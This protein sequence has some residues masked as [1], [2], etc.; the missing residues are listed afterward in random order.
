MPPTLIL[1]NGGL[2]SVLQTTQ[3][4][5]ADHNQEQPRISL[6]MMPRIYPSMTV[7]SCRN[8]GPETALKTLF[9]PL[10]I[11]RIQSSITQEASLSYA[12]SARQGK[13]A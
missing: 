13:R 8:A 7:P 3:S 9:I 4:G 2:R 6:R 5:V 11:S 12:A 10:S 1:V